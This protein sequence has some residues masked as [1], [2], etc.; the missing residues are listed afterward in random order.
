MKHIPLLEKDDIKDPEFK[1]FWENYQF[2]L[3]LFH[4][5]A[6]VPKAFKAYTAFN[7]TIW[8]EDDDGFPLLLKEMAVVQASVIANSSYESGN[9]GASMVR[10]GGTQEQLDAL[11]AG[12]TDSDLFSEAEKLVIKFTNEM[13]V[14]ARPTEETLTAMSETY[15]N[16]QISELTWGICAYMTNSRF[17]NL[18]GCE[19]GDDEDYG[20]MSLG[21]KT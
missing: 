9:H 6:H 7:R 16:K 8:E 2:D 10:R 20:M 14:D 21:R 12:D 11:I 19:I 13:V 15:S 4:V 18:G 3:A 1:A 17:A 5:W